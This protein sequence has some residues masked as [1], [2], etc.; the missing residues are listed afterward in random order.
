MARYMAHSDA[1]NFTC[2]LHWKKYYEI[3]LFY[4]YKTLCNIES[5]KYAHVDWYSLIVVG[6]QVT[7]LI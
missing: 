3:T 2:H 1:M 4:I 7:G 6:Q 5:N